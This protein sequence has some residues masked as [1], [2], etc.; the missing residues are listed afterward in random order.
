MLG[1]TK[2]MA[3]SKRNQSGAKYASIIGHRNL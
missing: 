1:K 3:F 2:I